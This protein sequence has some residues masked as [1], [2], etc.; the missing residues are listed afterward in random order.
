MALPSIEESNYLVW[1]RML[2]KSPLA[3]AGDKK[4]GRMGVWRCTLWKQ[5]A[6]RRS[7]RYDLHLD[8]GSGKA[9]WRSEKVEE[10]KRMLS[11]TIFRYRSAFQ[12][13]GR[14]KRPLFLT[15]ITSDQS[16]SLTWQSGNIPLSN[17]DESQ[18]E[19]NLNFTIHSAKQGKANPSFS[20]QSR[21]HKNGR[22]EG[23]RHYAVLFE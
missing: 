23:E 13:I 3:Y 14:K 20:P 18:S 22:R 5:F 15:S 17:N 2:L 10:K 12:L 1:V 16:S 8:C 9:A 11:P 6:P 21:S 7:P 4:E 19:P